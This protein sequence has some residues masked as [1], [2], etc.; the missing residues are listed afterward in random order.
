MFPCVEG[1]RGFLDPGAV[2]SCNPNLYPDKDTN[3]YAHHVDTAGDEAALPSVILIAGDVWV[4]A[5]RWLWKLQWV[6]A[7]N[8]FHFGLP[9]IAT[10]M[11]VVTFGMKSYETIRRYV[12]CTTTR[13]WSIN[14]ACTY[15]DHSSRMSQSKL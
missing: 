7:C 1:C 11:Y 15:T 6:C 10:R 3:M 14:A 12:R 13:P 4:E 8:E 2:V 5:S 9:E